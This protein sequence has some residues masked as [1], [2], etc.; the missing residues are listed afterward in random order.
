MNRFIYFFPGCGSQAEGESALAAAGL[1]D[2]IE[3]AG[4]F[5]GRVDKGP[6]IAS[7]GDAE[8]APRGEGQETEQ[9]ADLKS[10]GGE[11]Q[12]TEPQGGMLLTNCP[13]GVTPQLVVDAE[14][15]TW[16]HFEKFS[17]GYWND[18]KPGPGDLE[19]P[20]KIR[21]WD[22]RLGD[23]TA[24]CVPLAIALP[25]AKTALPERFGVAA[26]GKMTRRVIEKYAELYGY[27]EQLFDAAKAEGGFAKDEAEVLPWAC[28]ALGANYFGG[29]HEFAGALGLFDT[30]TLGDTL[31]AIVNAPAWDM[32]RAMVDG[33]KNLPQDFYRRFD[34]FAGISQSTFPTL[35]I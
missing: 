16:A 27:G 9:S 17:I 35:P 14:R 11:G 3:A 21:G 19:R 22:V 28:A 23:G 8:A 4:R 34:G 6:R 2:A 5:W 29:V 24:W 13:A 1:S 15:Q 7:R 31:A 10:Q 26:D 25:F 20:E 30:K 32:Y 18:R 33:K 12:G